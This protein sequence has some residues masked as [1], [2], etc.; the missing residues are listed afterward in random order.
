[1]SRLLPLAAACLL[2]PTSGSSIEYIS[3][4][5]YFGFSTCHEAVPFDDFP[6]TRV[7]KYRPADFTVEEVTAIHSG[8]DA[9]SSDDPRNIGWNLNLEIN[10]TATTPNLG[11]GDNNLFKLDTTDSTALAAV[12]FTG[13]SPSTGIHAYHHDTS[14]SGCANFR[15]LESD[16]LFDTSEPFRDRPDW[17]APPPGLPRHM[18]LGVVAAHEFGHHMG[19]AHE[20]DILTMMTSI[21]PTMGAPSGGAVSIDAESATFMRHEHPATATGSNLMVTKYF[22]VPWDNTEGFEIR[23][24]FVGG[25]TTFHA[26]SRV[27][28]NVGRDARTSRDV[29]RNQMRAGPI[30]LHNLGATTQSARLEYW[31]IAEGL[32]GEDYEFGCTPSSAGPDDLWLVRSQII[33]L[34]PNEPVF[35]AGPIDLPH[36]PDPNDPG[37][38]DAEGN[39]HPPRDPTGGSA[40]GKRYHLC[41][42]IDADGAVA[43]TDEYDNVAI[44]DGVFEVIP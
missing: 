19:L 39:Y 36:L 37:Y 8:M 38:F 32:V 2:L 33:S 40:T 1:M 4:S 30:G 21:P 34:A 27:A 18:D 6:T 43:E 35:V 26:G 7:F 23:E 28:T 42:M 11:D 17:M 20:D 13:A 24:W 9:W 12:G 44:S 25:E 15:L 22:R 14:V 5:N 16:I 29:N 41:V 31:L 10:G 3:K